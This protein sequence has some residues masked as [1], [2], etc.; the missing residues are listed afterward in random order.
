MPA[1]CAAFSVPGRP[2]RRRPLSGPFDVVLRGS[3]RRPRCIAGG[4]RGHEDVASGPTPPGDL[5]RTV[6]ASDDQTSGVRARTA[7][8]RRPA[9]HRCRPALGGRC[10]DRGGG[11]RDPDRRNVR[12]PEMAAWPRFR[13]PPGLRSARDRRRVAAGPPS[14]PGRRPSRHPR[15]DAV[16]G[17]GERAGHLSRADRGFLQRGARQE[18]GGCDRIAGHRL[19]R[20]RVALADRPVGAPL[21]R[22][23][24][25]AGG[26]A[27]VLAV[28]RRADP[29]QEPACR[30]A[31]AEPGGGAPQASQP[32]ADED[33]QG[34]ARCGGAQHLGHQRPGEHGAA[35]DGPPAGTRQV[36]PDDHQRREQAGTG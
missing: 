35:P 32:G 16:G 21:D 4:R 7:R 10:G 8:T 11:D 22:V 2:P 31:A 12:G 19:R 13:R 3:D 24:A 5:A 18:E 34:P 30:R 33:G 6:I 29:Q 1:A 14:L 36:G 25:R 9:A 17:R 27:D 23:R 28:R 26:R 15:H 20:I